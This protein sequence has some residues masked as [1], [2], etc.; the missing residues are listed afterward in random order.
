MATERG[1]VCGQS[2]NVFSK[3]KLRWSATVLLLTLFVLPFVFISHLFLLL[4]V[5][6]FTGFVLFCFLVASLVLV[7]LLSLAGSQQSS[8]SAVIA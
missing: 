1:F 4:L 6:F 5:L 7:N 3:A 8:D 2:V